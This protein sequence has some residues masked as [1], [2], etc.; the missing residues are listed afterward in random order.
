MSEAKIG[1]EMRKIR[2]A[3]ENI[4]PV[5]QIKD[6]EKHV[7]RYKT[8]VVS[9]KEVGLVEPLVV[10]PQ[11]DVPG[12]YLLL[13]GH[14]RLVALKELGETSA[15][16]IIAND[17]ECFTYN[18]R[19]SRLP[20]IQEHR[21]IT[22]AVHNGVSPERIAAALNMPYRVVLASMRLLNGIHEEAADLLKDKN[23]APKAIRLLKRVNGVRQIEIAELMVSA[24]NYFT[25][26]A[27]A[28]VLGTS[29]DQLVNPDEPKKKE[30]MSPEDIARMEQEMESLERDLKAIGDTYSE[31]MF[32][33]TCA[34]G[35]IKKLSENAKVVRF[36]N[37]N[38][39]DIFSEFE[40]IAAAETV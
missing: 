10:H 16:C 17:D 27:E 32:N 9:L 25:G 12:K 18:A 23:I 31:N 26:Y 28:L 24:N 7:H 3:L 19:V 29:K 14:L 33:L 34:R 11:K 15:D 8:I 1:F 2:L 30:G 21:M 37:G 39:P 38:H 13:D 5:R 22:K 35:Y 40:S 36:L 6:P 20:P 4:L